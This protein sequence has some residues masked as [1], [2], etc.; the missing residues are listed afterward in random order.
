MNGS[1]QPCAFAPSC[2]PGHHEPTTHHQTHHKNRALQPLSSTKRQRSMG[3]RTPKA[4]SS[5]HIPRRAVGGGQCF[6]CGWWPPPPSPLPPL[7][8][9]TDPP[10]FEHHH[11]DGV[12]GHPPG[13]AKKRDR[14]GGGGKAWRSVAR[15]PDP[16]PPL[17]LL[18]SSFSLLWPPHALA[19]HAPTHS[20]PLPR[21]GQAACATRHISLLGA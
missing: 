11:H 15:H 13:Q 5:P 4:S 10:P 20:L 7:L 16:W 18:S 19:P 14:D 1:P 3:Q 17:P 12:G 6:A 2:R 21:A 8:P 9:S